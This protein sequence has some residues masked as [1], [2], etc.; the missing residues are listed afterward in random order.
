MSAC[1]V[2]AVPFL[3][4]RY[5]TNHVANSDLDSPAIEQSTKAFSVPN[6]SIVTVCFAFVL[7]LGLP[8]V[9]IVEGSGNSSSGGN[10][11][12]PKITGRPSP[13]RPIL[14]ILQRLLVEP[15]PTDHEATQTVPRLPDCPRPIL[16]A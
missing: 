9:E 14:A 3:V 16:L 5:S 15:V 4:S 1:E 8:F 2:Q 13:S 7:A 10:P 12:E 6:R 11:P